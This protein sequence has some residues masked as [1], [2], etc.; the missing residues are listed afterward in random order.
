MQKEQKISPDISANTEPNREKKGNL[1]ALLP[2]LVFL[3][4]YIGVSVIFNDFYLMSVV[5]AFLAALLVGCLQNRKLSFEKKLAV[6]AKGISDPN[7]VTMILIF[8]CAG[9]FAGILGREGASAVADL[10]LSFIPARF[11]V[12]VMFLVACFVSTAMGTSVGTITVIAPI[13]VAVAAATGIS[14]TLTVASIV[15]GAMFGD[16]L[17]FIS[18]TTIAATS[19]QG[20][21]MRDKFRENF[22]IAFPAALLTIIILLVIALN[23]GEMNEYIPSEINL[24]LLLPYFLVLVGGILG[25]NVFVVLIGGITIATIVRLCL[26]GSV[27]TVISAMGTGSVGMFEVIIVTLLVSMLSALMRE[28]GGFDALLYNIKRIF[29]GRVGGQLGIATLVS[30]MDVATANNTVAIVMSAPIAKNISDEYGITNTKTASLLDI[31]GSVIQGLIPYG[32]QL[33]IA[34]QLTGISAA[35]M[36]PYMFYQYLLAISAVVF[37]FLPSFKLRRK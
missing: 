16:N 33:L 3:V 28:F 1:I 23:S 6:M 13:G 19:T 12:L 25:I 30:A 21:K 26:G 8:L 14:P 11:A 18:D 27:S 9:I 36:M 20:C 10:L 22:F 2:I 24:W 29:R 7:I 37:M 34:A 4:I 17:S 5:V 15:G 31:F 32:A 35:E